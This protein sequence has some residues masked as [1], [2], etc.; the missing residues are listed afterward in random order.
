M[1]ASMSLDGDVDALAAYYAEW[2]DTYDADVTSEAYE[3]PAT[4]VELLHDVIER[5]EEFETFA[6]SD[7]SILDAGCGTGLVGVE[8][9]AAG[10]R[11]LHGIDLSPEMAERARRRGVYDSVEGGVDLTA[12][13]RAAE[14]ASVAVAVVA[15]VF[16]VGHVAPAA[17][18]TVAR[19]VRRGGLLLVSTRRAYLESTDYVAVSDQLVAGGVLELLVRIEDGPYTMDSTADYWAYRVR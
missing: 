13:P 19:R 14:R 4:I 18:E 7:V 10:Y 8:L 3:L 16:T 12:E 11:N 6:A 2:A 5:G 1:R 9:A 15:G 17:L